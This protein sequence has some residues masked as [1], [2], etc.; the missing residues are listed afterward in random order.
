MA[1]P[2]PPRLDSRARPGQDDGS[3]P[4]LDGEAWPLRRW[5]GLAKTRWQS[6][7]LD[8]MVAPTPDKMAEPTTRL[9]LPSPVLLRAPYTPSHDFCQVK[10]GLWPSIPRRRH[11]GWASI[12]A[13]QPLGTILLQEA[14]G[15]R[16]RQ[17]QGT[18]WRPRGIS[19]PALLGKTR[20]VASSSRPNRL[21]LRARAGSWGP[22]WHPGHE[23]N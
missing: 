13:R 1:D 4:G 15:S 11:G 18:S 16:L 20:T 7:T 14:E 12:P 21:S 17:G 10:A 3:H 2:A 6:S 23:E 19:S 22:K 5:Q 9:A 8:K